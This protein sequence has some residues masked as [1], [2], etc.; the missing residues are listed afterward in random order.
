ML[1]RQWVH[2]AEC[3]CTYVLEGLAH[4]TTG[5]RWDRKQLQQVLTKLAES[6][7][8]ISA[9]TTALLGN[10]SPLHKVLASPEQ[11]KQRGIHPHHITL[12]LDAEAKIMLG[13]PSL[14]AMTLESITKCPTHAPPKRILRLPCST[15]RASGGALGPKQKV[16]V[17]HER[18]FWYHCWRR[19]P[20]I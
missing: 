10:M 1:M 20:A 18:T 6:P 11:D 4:H 3:T 19:K 9:P 2:V 8:L 16:S 14:L 5:C 7:T 15:S 12:E 13:G 17:A